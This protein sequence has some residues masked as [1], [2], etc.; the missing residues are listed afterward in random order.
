[1]KPRYKSKLAQSIHSGKPPKPP[2]PPKPRSFV[3]YCNSSEG[4]ELARIYAAELDQ[5]GS[6]FQEQNFSK[7]KALVSPYQV[8]KSVNIH[9][10][11]M[12][13]F[14]LSV[15]PTCLADP[16]G[17]EIKKGD[18]KEAQRLSYSCTL[19]ILE[20]SHTEL[21]KSIDELFSEA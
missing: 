5:W 2:K 1:M 6:D 18:Y 20:V 14:V 9:L 12:A 16:V 7:K 13:E 10:E 19:G 4:Q 8:Y 17:K 21:K 15:F 11:M 3:E